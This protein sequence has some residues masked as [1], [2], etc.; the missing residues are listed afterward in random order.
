MAVLQKQI[1]KLNVLNFLQFL[2]DAST[3]NAQHVLDIKDGK[4]Y[5]KITN[6]TKEFIKYASAPL[7]GIGGD[8]SDLSD[9]AYRFY[10]SDLDKIIKAFEI[11][12]NLHKDVVNVKVNCVVVEGEGY[13]RIEK[14]WLEGQL[15]LQ[16]SAKDSSFSFNYVQDEKWDAMMKAPTVVEFDLSL[17]DINSLKK[18]FNYL[19][20]EDTKSK[21]QQG[22]HIWLT[23]TTENVDAIKFTEED[24][25]MFSL[26]HTTNVIF[27]GLTNAHF[28]CHAFTLSLFDENLYKV[29]IK[30][31]NEIYIIVAV[32]SGD[33]PKTIVIPMINVAK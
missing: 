15:K 21:N 2:T 14:L 27:N 3:S 18:I 28:T 9:G 11:A 31:Y 12:K 1:K 20:L 25:K 32:P 13:T 10:M 19:T 33:S 17:N 22:L 7:E 16:I 29:H 24:E 5:T 6:E 8:F 4:L 26:I 30:H 23:R